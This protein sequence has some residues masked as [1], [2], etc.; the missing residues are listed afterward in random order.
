[1][2]PARKVN[3]KPEHEN[4]MHNDLLFPI[5]GPEPRPLSAAE[6]ARLVGA[7][8][9]ENELSAVASVADEHDRALLLE[10]FCDAAPKN[11]RKL[12]RMVALILFKVKHGDKRPVGGDIITNTAKFFHP[13]CEGSNDHRLL[14]PRAILIVRP[15]LRALLAMDDEAKANVLLACGWPAPESVNWYAVKPSKL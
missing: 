15:D 2:A 6:R 12:A 10:F 14:Y 13:E 4:H 1:M 11:W 5:P 7:G 9:G 3:P 8:C